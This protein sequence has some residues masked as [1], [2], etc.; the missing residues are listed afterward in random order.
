MSKSTNTD[1]LLTSEALHIKFNKPELNSG[2]RAGKE[3]NLF[4]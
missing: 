4:I 1:K 2:L 3:L